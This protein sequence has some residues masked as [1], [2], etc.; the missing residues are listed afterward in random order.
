MVLRMKLMGMSFRDVP[1]I[2]VIKVNNHY[3]QATHNS[4][5]MKCTKLH[6][7]HY[8]TRSVHLHPELCRRMVMH[9]I[10]QIHGVKI[11][12]RTEEVEEA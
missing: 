2:R 10:C 12:H 5:M 4:I 9:S 7:M 11:R 6:S 3:L 8:G 1:R